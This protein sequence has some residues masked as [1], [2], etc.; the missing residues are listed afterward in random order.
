MNRTLWG[1]VVWAVQWWRPVCELRAWWWA[2]TRQ[3]RA[4]WGW[5]IVDAGYIA[6]WR[7][8]A[9][10]VGKVGDGEGL[11]HWRAVSWPAE[12]DGLAGGSVEAQRAAERAWW[13]A[14]LA[15]RIRRA[16]AVRNAKG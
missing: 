13:R 15:G 10:E 8:C 3:V 14:A 5:S 16:R 7:G 9:L 6:D 2:W 4:P 11:W 1:R 12:V